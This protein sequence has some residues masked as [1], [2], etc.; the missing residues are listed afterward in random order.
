MF[1]ACLTGIQGT[2]S[3]LARRCAIRLLSA[4][5]TSLVS[6]RSR[7]VCLCLNLTRWWL[8]DPESNAYDPLDGELSQKL[9]S[10]SY[11]SLSR[12]R[13]STST[14]DPKS[15]PQLDPD[16]N[17]EELSLFSIHMPGVLTLDQVKALDLDHWYL[18]VH[19]SFVHV[20]VRTSFLSL[21]DLQLLMT[22]ELGPRRLGTNGHG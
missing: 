21:Q 14:T 16:V 4:L 17:E 10:R 2:I 8:A 18:V 6:L 15:E 9:D 3:T 13:S 7:S 22:H 1:N 11:V 20:N 5:N 19:G 12:D